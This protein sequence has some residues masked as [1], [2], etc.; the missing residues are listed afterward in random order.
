MQKA[1]RRNENESTRLYNTRNVRNFSSIF[2]HL[3]HTI[4]RCRSKQWVLFLHAGFVIP[5]TK[6]CWIAGME[7][8]S[9]DQLFQSWW[10]TWGTYC[11]PMSVRYVTCILW[12]LK[13][14]A[15]S[16]LSCQP[17]Q[18][19]IAGCCLLEL[20]GSLGFFCCPLY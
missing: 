8:L 3:P 5:G 4:S 12:W 17:S 14:L 19:S 2:R 7:I 15:E 9:R 6:Q 11:K 13:P 16:V 1:E 18:H 10:S 20:S